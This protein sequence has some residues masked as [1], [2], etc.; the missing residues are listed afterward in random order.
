[1]HEAS[2]EGEHVDVGVV[3]TP[4][5]LMMAALCVALVENKPNTG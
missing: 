5:T 2:R 1:M 3:S 4:L